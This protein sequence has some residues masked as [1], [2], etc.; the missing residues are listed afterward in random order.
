M[1]LRGKTV[2]VTG[3]TGFIGG[4]LV[5]KL[6]LTCQA[7]VRALVR[8]FARAS[9][10]ARFAVENDW[11]LRQLADLSGGGWHGEKSRKFADAAVPI[12]APGLRQR[13]IWLYMPYFGT[14]PNYFQLYLNSLG[15]NA[16]CLSV[17]L[18]TDND[19]SNYQVPENLIKIPTTLDVLRETAARFVSNE[20]RIQ[21]RPDALLKQPY[22]LCDFRIMYPALFKDLSKRYGVTEDDFV[23]WGDCDVIYGR[24]SDFLNMDDDYHIIGG[25]HGHLTAVRNTDSFRQLF[26]ALTNLPE[27]LID[28]ESHAV[29]EIAFRKPLLDFLK[30][31]Q[32]RMFF[33]NRYFCDITPECFCDHPEKDIDHLYYDRDGRLTVVYDDGESRQAIYCHLQKRAMSLDFDQYDDGYYIY[34]NAFRLTPPSRDDRP[35]LGGSGSVEAAVMHTSIA[36]RRDQELPVGCLHPPSFLEE[37]KHCVKARG[38]GL[39]SHKERLLFDPTLVAYLAKPGPHC[40]EIGAGWSSRPDWLAT[41][42]NP[43][44]GLPCMKLDATES[45]E[46][47]SES[48]DFIYSED[49]IEHVSFEDGRNMLEECNRILKPGGVIRIVTPSLGFLSRVISSD[50]GM[51]EERYRTWSVT[52]F[53]PEAPKVTNAFFLNNFVR[54]CG[55]TFIYDRET[56]ELA[57]KLSGFEPVIACELN[58][59]DHPLLCGLA[60]VRK[61]PSGFLDL[62]SMTLE[63]TKARS[64]ALPAPKGPNLALSKRATQSSLSPW[65]LEATPE[66]EA[67]R[68]VS[69]HLTGSYNC[70]TGLDSPPWWRVDLEESQQIGEVRIHNRVSPDAAILARGSRLAIQVSDDDRSWRTVFRKETPT[71]LRGPTRNSPFIWAPEEPVFGRYLRIQLLDTQYLHLEQVEICG[72]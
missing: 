7:N 18:M 41:D 20:F 68:V 35:I 53:A 72:P 11:A 38:T 32:F 17:F 48:F 28:E 69:G 8:H 57:L 21:M 55:H 58:K 40:L 23:G 49:M 26:R 63:G 9:R 3:S 16:E 61:I 60:N 2:L 47:P 34:E 25:F 22:K 37:Q 45:F 10:V 27:L 19:L 50:R 39:D 29:D 66:A 24:F 52:S 36:T 43:P 33:L 1:R 70:H 42:A 4:R 65:S 15:R 5:E 13:R 62:E 14:L 30:R 6:I 31:N 64:L 44:P 67:A 12:Q 56:L 54:A 51:I 71:L 46:I 59:S